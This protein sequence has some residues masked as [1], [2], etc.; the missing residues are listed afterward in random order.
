MSD[1]ATVKAV[2][3][4]PVP[5]DRGPDRH[6][7][8]AKRLVVR[9]YNAHHKH[10]SKPLT[11]ATVHIT[12]FAETVNGWKAVIASDVVRGLIWEVAFERKMDED[13]SEDVSEAHIGIWKRVNN[14]RIAC[15]EE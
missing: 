5:R 14:V 7:S 11:L 13:T 2:S 4:S 3:P 6:L 8:M 9:N 10:D 1:Q 12:W 15:K